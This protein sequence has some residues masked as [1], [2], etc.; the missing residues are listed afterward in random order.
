MSVATEPLTLHL[1][2]L[3][4]SIRSL[5]ARLD[6]A[7]PYEMHRT[8]MTG[9][10]AMDPNRVEHRVLWRLELPQDNP[11][12]NLRVL[13]QSPIMPDWS[14][15]DDQR[16]DRFPDDASWLSEPSASQTFD[17]SLRKG[18]QLRFRLRVNPTKRLSPRSRDE[19]GQ[20]VDRKSIGKR[21]ELRQPSEQIRWLA[22]HGSRCGFCLVQV[23]PRP[24]CDEPVFGVVGRSDGK[25]ISRKEISDKNVMSMTHFAVTFDGM[26]TVTDPPAFCNALIAGIGPAKAFGFG[27]LSI[28]PA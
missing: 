4:P 8:L 22:R 9:F 20:P 3:M 14:G 19:H 23:A 21:V 11:S 28:A 26:L 25:S 18:Q 6:L 7:N 1:S 13:V 16:R 17:P 27:L 5:R 2:K 15:L 12:R 24:D 10:P